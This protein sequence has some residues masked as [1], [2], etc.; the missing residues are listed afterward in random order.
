MNSCFT[1]CYVL[2][3]IGLFGF[4]FVAPQK[5]GYAQT[6]VPMP[7]SKPSPNVV[8]D[9]PKIETVPS[10]QA[11]PQ[12]KSQAKAKDVK[13]QPIVN[14]I[15]QPI[16]GKVETIASSYLVRRKPDTVARMRALTERDASLYNNA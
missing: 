7:E 14:P 6:S 8:F 16:A 9:Q 4:V 13:H 12:S 1:I 3:L 15:S 11:K 5:I 2:F 10:P